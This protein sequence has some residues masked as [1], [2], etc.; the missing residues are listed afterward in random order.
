MKPG[1][2]LFAQLLLIV[3]YRMCYRERVP[4]G[5]NMEEQVGIAPQ[6]HLVTSSH[7]LFVKPKCE[8]SSFPCL[9][10]V[11]SEEVMLYFC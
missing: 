11:I 3:W 6:S 10:S 2:Q 9:S 8:F 4:M 7:L 5:R 1:D